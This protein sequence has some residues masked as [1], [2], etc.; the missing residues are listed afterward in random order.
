MKVQKKLGDGS[1]FGGHYRLENPVEQAVSEAT[2]EQLLDE[3][4]QRGISIATE[5]GTLQ[6]Q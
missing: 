6:R 5:Q 4:A 2:T 3:L 1:P